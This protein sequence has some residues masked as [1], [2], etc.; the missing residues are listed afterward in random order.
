MTQLRPASLLN[1][2]CGSHYV[3]GWLNLDVVEEY[4]ADVH[5]SL[6]DIPLPDRSVDR[7]FASHV[8]EHL[9]YH[10]QMPLVLAEFLRVLAD[11]GELCVVGPDIERAV[12]CGEPPA[13]LHAIIAWPAD[14]NLGN[15]PFMTP[16]TGHAWTATGPF[17]EHA[18]ATAGFTHVT[19]SGRLRDIAAEGW[20]LENFGDW[21]NA[22]VCRKE[23]S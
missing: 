5:A 15:W 7:V 23:P 11:D 18:L 8:L 16:P 13:L 14:F 21:Q 1:A 19:Y 10:R 22:Y 4:R 6:T 20:P 12:A 3:D 9:D 17:V 2:G